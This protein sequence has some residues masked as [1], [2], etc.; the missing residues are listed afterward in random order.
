MNTIL[1]IEDDPAILTGLVASLQE[2]HF[3]VLTATDG[4]TGQK[5]ALE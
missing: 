5:M 3:T 1:I 2:E 4:I